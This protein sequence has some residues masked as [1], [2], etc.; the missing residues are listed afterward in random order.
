MYFGSDHRPVYGIYEVNIEAPFLSTLPIYSKQI[1][2]SGSIKFNKLILDLPLDQFQSF[3]DFECPLPNN[4]EFILKFSA[5]FLS[6]Y[7]CTMPL[8]MIVNIFQQ[9]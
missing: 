9:I 5:R 8:K 2:P 1:I 6:N 7:P 3:Q 4:F